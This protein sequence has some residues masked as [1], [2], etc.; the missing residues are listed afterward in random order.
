MHK[1]G[2]PQSLESAN[3]LLMFIRPPHCITRLPRSLCERSYWKANEW[4]NWLL[5]YSVPCLENLLPHRYWKHWCLLAEA[6]W[7]LLSTRISQE[8]ISHAES[9]LKRFV[10]QV[11]RLYNTKMMTFNMHQL[12]HLAKS[13]RDLGPL[14]AHSAFVFETGNETSAF[15]TI[16]L[17]SFRGIVCDASCNSASHRES[18][19]AL[20]MQMS[21]SL[22]NSLR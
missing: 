20:L 22:P 13:V 8:M 3:K 9:L 6:I 4:R 12:L 17:K 21:S 15:A 7:I 18:N 5:Y 1:V 16:A 11:L 10:D 19:H 14:W 2:S